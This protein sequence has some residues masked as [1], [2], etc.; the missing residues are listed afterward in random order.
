MSSDDD[1]Y[2]SDVEDSAGEIDQVFCYFKISS[3]L[4]NLNLKI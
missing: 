1:S 3:S 2:S 4:L